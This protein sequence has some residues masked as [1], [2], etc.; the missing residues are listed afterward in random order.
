MARPSPKFADAAAY[1]AVY[2]DGRGQVAAT[3]TNDGETLRVVLRGVAFEGHDFDCL[4]PAGG[5]DAA[6]E[7]ALSNAGFRLHHGCLCNCVLAWTMPLRVGGPGG[8]A[9]EGAL[10]CSL[11]LGLPAPNQGLD[12][13]DLQLTLRCSVGRFA[14]SGRGGMFEDELGEITAQLPEGFFLH[15]C[16]GCAWGDY[17]PLGNGSFGGMFCFR[18]QRAAYAA[19]ETKDAYLPLVEACDRVVQET[20]V[21]GRFQRRTPGTGYRG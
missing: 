3:I 17:S 4:E 13:E 14:G 10:A 19:A 16:I 5:P 1:P 20:Y 11:T 12:R 8:H 2:R 21:C 6:P 9:E 15:A 18:D 7:A